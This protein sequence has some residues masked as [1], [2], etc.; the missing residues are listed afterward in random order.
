MSVQL[1]RSAG[2]CDV[3]FARTAGVVVPKAPTVRR[4]RGTLGTPSLT[5]VPAKN[6]LHL[7]A[8]KLREPQESRTVRAARVA[9]RNAKDFHALTGAPE[10]KRA[11]WRLFYPFPLRTMDG[12]VR[13]PCPN[14]HVVFGQNVKIPR[15][16]LR[17]RDQR[18]SRS[19]QSTPPSTV[20]VGHLPASPSQRRDV[21][22]TCKPPGQLGSL[23]GGDD[24]I[25]LLLPPVVYR[26][27][28]ILRWKQRQTR[29]AN[30]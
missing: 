18:A 12:A 15:L 25:G 14:G 20:R 19:P 26:R 30:H 4:T 7:A 17:H 13:N 16:R 24:F 9:C 27:R 3:R 29:A 28:D 1:G 5:S 10:G 23:K 6:R 21:G 2:H 8:V 22:I 11:S